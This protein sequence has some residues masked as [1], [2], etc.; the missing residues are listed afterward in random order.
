MKSSTAMQSSAEQIR[1]SK[2]I[3]ILDLALEAHGILCG[4]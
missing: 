1:T 3:H 2:K 4:V